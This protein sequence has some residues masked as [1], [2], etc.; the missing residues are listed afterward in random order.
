MHTLGE[1][2]LLLAIAQNGTITERDKMHFALAGSEL[3]RLAALRRIEFVKGRI[4][5]IDPSPTH[6]PFL[7]EAFTTMLASKRPQRARTWVASQRPT[8][9]GDYLDSLA[10]SGAVRCEVHKTMGLFKTQR[11]FVT[12]P[13]RLNRLMSKI[14]AIAFSSGPVHASQAAFGGLV[15]AIGLSSMLYPTHKQR[16]ARKRLKSL[17]EYDDAAWA[18]T[19]VLGAARA[20]A[21][22]NAAV[23]AGT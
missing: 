21:A 15:H 13:A 6:D 18:V 8:V 19:E 12:D 1:D 11:W 20:S 10:A 5:V 23:I 3:A 7:D 14:D 17:A 16:A 22:A 2:I 4:V 9:T